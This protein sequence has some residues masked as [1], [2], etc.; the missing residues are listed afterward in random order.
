M[1]NDDETR[2]DTKDTVEHAQLNFPE[3]SSRPPANL[4]VACRSAQQWKAALASPASTG[5]GA[6]LRRQSA[7]LDELRRA[8]SSCAVNVRRLRS[9][10]DTERHLADKQLVALKAS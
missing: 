4:P 8:S 3:L 10:V 7:V 5:R 9:L 6:Q 1:T 2:K